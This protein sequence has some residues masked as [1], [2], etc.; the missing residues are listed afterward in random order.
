VLLIDDGDWMKRSTLCKMDS[1]RGRGRP[2][3]TWNQVVD[4][5]MRE[6]GLDE[7]EDGCENPNS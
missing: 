6:C 7:I 2:R 5:D 4:E 1:M 3:K